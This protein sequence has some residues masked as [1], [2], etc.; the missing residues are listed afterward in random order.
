MAH[1]HDKGTE[2]AAFNPNLIPVNPPHTAQNTSNKNLRRAEVWDIN[3][4]MCTK[5]SHALMNLLLEL[6]IQ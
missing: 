1:V 3:L 2:S 6:W 4:E 5:R